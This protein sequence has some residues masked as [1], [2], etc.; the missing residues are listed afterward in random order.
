[1]ATW[2]RSCGSCGRCN[3]RSGPETA[4]VRPPVSCWLK[5]DNDAALHTFDRLLVRDVHSC[6]PMLSRAIS[7]RLSRSIIRLLACSPFRDGI[8][9]ST[10]TLPWL[11]DCS[12]R[13][14]KTMLRYAAGVR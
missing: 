12:L 2:R 6:L 1:M 10:S 5:T 13:L 11:V 4:P 8:P 9:C 3:G 7:A 14:P